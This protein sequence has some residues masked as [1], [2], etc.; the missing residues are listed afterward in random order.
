MID[1]TKKCEKM[2]PVQ[3]GTHQMLFQ[4]LLLSSSFLMS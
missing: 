4:P 3:N 1:T 2:E